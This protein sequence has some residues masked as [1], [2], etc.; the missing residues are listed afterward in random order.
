MD[1]ERLGFDYLGADFHKRGQPKSPHDQHFQAINTLGETEY[2]QYRS[3]ANIE[4][5]Q[6]P[7]RSEM[8]ERAR[9]ITE[10]AIRCRQTQRNEM[11]WRLKLE[12]QVMA[13]FEFEV[14]W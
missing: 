11:E 3:E 12:H 10:F 1:Y 7:W 6:K 14:T 8:R 2:D 13:R 9:M 4:A 5:A